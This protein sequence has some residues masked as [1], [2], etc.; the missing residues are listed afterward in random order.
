M[1]FEVLEIVSQGVGNSEVRPV[2][3]GRY[4]GPFVAVFAALA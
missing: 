4:V 1:P 3:D 2:S